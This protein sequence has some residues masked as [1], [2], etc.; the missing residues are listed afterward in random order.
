MVGVCLGLG[1]KL[2]V[3]LG[4]ELFARL[5]ISRVRSRYWGGARHR[6]EVGLGVV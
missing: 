1:V 5:G 4:L 6:D 2:G 3:K